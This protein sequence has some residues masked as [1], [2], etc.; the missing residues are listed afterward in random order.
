MKPFST[1]LL[2]L[3]CLFTIAPMT[4]RG[5]DLKLTETADT[6]RISLRDKTV[7][8]YVKTARPVPEGIEKH[9]SRSGYI[10]P[11]SVASGCCDRCLS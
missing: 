5:G 4:V 9:F 7:L 8:E 11:I 10:H 3:L 6:L 1:T 2:A